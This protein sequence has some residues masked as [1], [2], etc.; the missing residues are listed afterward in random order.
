MS[1]EGSDGPNG[2]AHPIC[3]PCSLQA[4]QQQQ[5]AAG[6]SQPAGG[7][8]LDSL[9]A[10]VEEAVGQARRQ[11]QAA[12]AD[13]AYW[14]QQF[15]QER[16][17]R[18]QQE[19]QLQQQQQQQEQQLAWLDAA[20]AAVA[21]SPPASPPTSPRAAHARQLSADERS[22]SVRTAVVA[23]RTAAGVPRRHTA[24][25]LR[26]PGTLSS[27]EL[28][29]QLS[30]TASH[31]EALRQELER[32]LEAGKAAAGSLAL[33]RLS[34]LLH[35]CSFLRDASAAAC[36]RRVS[37]DMGDEMGQQDS[38]PC[39]GD[40][41]VALHDDG[42]A[43]VGATAAAAVS[44][45]LAQSWAAAAGARQASFRHAAA[46]EGRVRP[47]KARFKLVAAVPRS[48]RSNSSRREQARSDK[49]AVTGA[50]GLQMSASASRA[51]L[52]GGA[53][54][55]ATVVEPGSPS[56][57]LKG[58]L[59]ASGSALV[60]LAEA[61]QDA[62]DDQQEATWRASGQHLKLQW[63]SQPTTVLVVFK[64]V[65]AVFQ[66]SVKA[67]AWLLQRGLTVYV[68]PEAWEQLT[69][70]VRE[71]M[72]NGDHTDSSTSQAAQGGAPSGLPPRPG[73]TASGTSRLA[74]GGGPKQGA[75][76]GSALSSML[77]SLDS[78]DGS[79]VG[80]PGLPPLP[81]AAARPAVRAVDLAT[82]LRT[83]EPPPCGCPP[84]VP[85]E[86]GHQVDL[87]ITLGGDGT[88][89]W[90]CGLFRAGAVP[91]LVPLAMG[92]LGF[93]TPF[94]IGGQLDAVL[95]RVISVDRGM[96]LM[97]RHRLQ[98]RVIRGDASSPD[99][100]SAAANNACLEEFVVLNEV[101]IDRGMTA[102][103]CNLQC[104]VDNAHVT[105]VQGDGLI[106]AT[107]TGSTAYNLA[108]G[109]SMVHPAVP[110]FLFTPICP[111]SL[112]SRPLV[113]PEH[114]TLRIKVP[115]DS[116]SSAYCSFDGRSRQELRPGDAVM[117][118]MSQWPAP[119]VCHL[120]ASHDWFLSMRE[121]L[122]WNVR[123]QQAG[124]GQ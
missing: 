76:G 105:V 42:A 80:M 27:P 112:S 102:Q 93:M 99:L 98:C 54:A 94:E 118:S 92:S 71:Y 85:C 15:E 109:G 41:E 10:G 121:G 24:P 124:R 106:V 119:M 122:S 86:V 67:V 77:S 83:W 82:Q 113:L 87:V 36:S 6:G 95:S 32:D 65:P 72:A 19:E 30:S 43:G 57:P 46:V 21:G 12:Q 60:N 62:M 31:L 3:A 59:L 79:E 25:A 51:S 107:P 35:A 114:V 101:V 90:T 8:G 115:L 18:E 45:A 53:A 40:Q 88:V 5:P 9:L 61:E 26:A 58:A 120:D 96:P 103:L 70:G 78:Q 33:S 117:I 69:P 14:R 29:S 116:R 34:S 28:L 73:H 56:M 38:S 91:P 7:N 37:A 104:F 17:L 123:K 68:E 52:A 23:A 100:A 1:K 75:G 50:A 89:L 84:A 4:Q 11:A 55:V 22:V 20:A 97:L 110:C 16:R 2:V 81:P 48:Y 64:P 108:A 39:A 47:G 13:A 66:S 74:N 49:L 111:H 44:V 63:L